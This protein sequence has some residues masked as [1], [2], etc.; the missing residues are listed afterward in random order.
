MGDPQDLTL[1]L[2]E[3]LEITRPVVSY[4]VKLNPVA[5]IH[6]SLLINDISV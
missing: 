4:R 5:Q 3:I 1:A 2:S 6:Y